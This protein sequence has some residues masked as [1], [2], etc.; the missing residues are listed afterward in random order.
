MKKITSLLFFLFIALTLT[1]QGKKWTLKECV[2]HALENNISVKQSA[3]DIELAE[4]EMRDANVI[5]ASLTE[6]QCI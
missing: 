6:C 5:S 2:Q 4:I 1:A 3:L